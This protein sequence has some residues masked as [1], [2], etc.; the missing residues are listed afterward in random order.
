MG[1]VGAGVAAIMSLAAA[2]QSQK[3]YA[4]EAQA[5]MEQAEMAQIEA[6]QQA[7]N[8]TAQLNEQLASIS[9]SSAGGGVSVGSSSMINIKRRE[10]KLTSQD[11]SSIKF[12]GS[13]KRRN[14]QLGAKGSKNKGKAAMYKGYADAASSGEQAYT[15]YNS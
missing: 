12:M 15:N 11:V 9:A 14:Y 6:D 4:A 1:G 10:S 2:K 8:R 7:I 5:Q 13:T 3:A